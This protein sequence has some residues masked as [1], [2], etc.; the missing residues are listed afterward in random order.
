[1]KRLW[2]PWR[3][4]YILDKNKSK[5]CLFC[6]ISSGKINKTKDKINLILFRGEYSFVLMNKYPYNSGHLMVVPY[7][8]T[9]TFN[10]LT[11]DALFEFIKIVKLSVDIL[12]KAL[13]PD[14]FNLGLNF[15]KVAGAGMESHMHLHIVP[16]WA[17]DTDS[18]PIIAET[19]VMPEHLNATFKKLT[20]IFKSAEK[21]S[22]NRTN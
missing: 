1:M 7:F 5:S 11:D 6:D 9:P 22:N 8:H 13:N 19:R 16:R 21:L 17:G 10:G 20:R 12:K 15:G 18:M 4:E 2:A 14:G 3:I